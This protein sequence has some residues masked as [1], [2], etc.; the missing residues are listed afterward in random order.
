MNRVAAAAAAS[1]ASPHLVDVADHDGG[2]EYVGERR[3][4]RVHRS[5]DVRVE[6]VLQNTKLLG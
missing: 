4:H 1:A 5:N 3:R 2:E 6:K